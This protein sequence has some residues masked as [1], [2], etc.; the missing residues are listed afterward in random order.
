MFRKLICLMTV[1]IMLAF[2]GCFASQTKNEVPDSPQ[3]VT[4][5]DTARKQEIRT[6]RLLIDEKEVPVKWE[7]NP[8][9]EALQKQLPLTIQMAKYGSFEQVGSIGR[10][11]VTDDRE[12]TAGYG[13]IMLYSGDK[14][15][16][17]Y[18]ANSWAYTRLGHVELTRQQMEEL[19]SK[20]DVKITLTAE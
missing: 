10:S 7:N 2:S 5:A 3:Q 18:G 9:V 11:I 20:A 4:Q 1:G 12:T 16:I 13:D 14:I 6:M 17:F 8:S 15:V 19:L